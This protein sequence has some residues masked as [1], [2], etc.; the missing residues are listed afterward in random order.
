VRD[1]VESGI[2]GVDIGA[3]LRVGGVR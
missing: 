3:T 1:G 2:T